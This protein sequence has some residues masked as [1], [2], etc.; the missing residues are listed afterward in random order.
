M[1]VPRGAR[2][3]LEAHEGAADARRRRRFDDRI[4]PD[5]AGEGV[6]GAAAGGHGAQR[7]DVHD[8]SSLCSACRACGPGADVPVRHT[9]RTSIIHFVPAFY[10][11]RSRPF[12]LTCRWQPPGL[13]SNPTASSLED[14]RPGSVRQ[15][16]PTRV[17]SANCPEVQNFLVLLMSE[18]NRSLFRAL[19]DPTGGAVQDHERRGAV[20]VPR[21]AFRWWHTDIPNNFQR[22]RHEAPFDRHVHRGGG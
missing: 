6:G 21:E 14:T 9:A 20:G 18:W 10:G 12:Y 17:S 4:L 16:R 3:R 2:A 7:F 19:W 15:T 13:P 1:G 8:S 11:L 5:R 22:D